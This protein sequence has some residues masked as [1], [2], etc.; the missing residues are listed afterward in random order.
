[1][2]SFEQGNNNIQ[3]EEFY[4]EYCSGWLW[5]GK[6]KESL[7]ENMHSQVEER[8]WKTDSAWNDSVRETSAAL[9]EELSCF[10][11]SR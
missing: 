6:W 10:T 3:S 5:R 8:S 7:Q 1:M 4:L 2:K 9:I 11:V